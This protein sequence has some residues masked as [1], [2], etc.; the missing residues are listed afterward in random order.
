MVLDQADAYLPGTCSGC[1]SGRNTIAQLA[2]WWP[3]WGIGLW[4]FTG[5]GRPRPGPFAPRARAPPRGRAPPHRPHPA[6]RK[7]R[8]HF[9]RHVRRPGPLF[10]RR[11]TPVADTGSANR[12]KRATWARWAARPYPVRL[13]GAGPTRPLLAVLLAVARPWQAGL[14]GQPR[15]RLVAGRRVAGLRQVALGRHRRPAAAQLVQG[16]L[17][18]LP[19]RCRGSLSSATG[20]RREPERIVAEGRFPS[21][22]LAAMSGRLPASSGSGEPFSA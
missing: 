3:K 7:D 15:P 19:Q 4:A 20:G 9:R 11:P 2:G 5:G 12:S 1:R 17:G 21:T 14:G 13:R 16:S 18:C 10:R 22:G 8:R 6:R